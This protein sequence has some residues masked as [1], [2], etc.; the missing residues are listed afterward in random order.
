MDESKNS[1]LSSKRSLGEF[2]TSNSVSNYV[3]SKIL[4]II[5]PNLLIEPFAGEGSLIG[6]FIELGIRCVINELNEK[7]FAALQHK[8][9]RKNVSVYNKDFIACELPYL[10]KEWIE[11]DTNKIF[12]FY[13]NP[14]FGTSSTNKL[15][16]KKFEYKDKK[17]R[18][19]KINYSG[20]EQYGK[21]DLLLPAIGKMIEFIKGIGSGYLAFYSPLGLF[22]K[23]KRYNKLLQALLK[24]FTFLWG[25]IFSGDKFFN[26]NKKKPIVVSVWQY[27]KNENTSISSMK[28]YY[29]TKLIPLKQVPLLKDYWRYD[30]RKRL[31]GEIAVQGNDRFNVMAPKLF[32]LKVEKGGSE[33]VPENLLKLLD[34]G[35]IPDE[36]AIGLWSV[37]VGHRS[38][39]TYPIYM[40]NAYVHIPD[41][42]NKEVKKILTMALISV[43]ISEKLNNYTNGKIRIDEKSGECYFGN[44]RLTEG[45]RFLLKTYDS[46]RIKD[47]AVPEILNQ[48]RSKDFIIDNSRYWRKI[49][50]EEIENL[51][52]EI[53]YWDFIPLPQT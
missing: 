6:P 21:G 30:T 24:D 48:L 27:I 25:E 42:S 28:F 41:F 29:D 36:L 26:V 19:I 31:Y 52:Y 1:Q 5:K 53:A 43:L 8:F 20:L 17:S 45:A 51:L 35:Y 46:L 14:P 2:F 40:D 49:L 11:K 47:V 18:N 3:G 37:T 23:R 50:R 32:H 34:V 15:A 9:E 44:Q 12:L 39:T 16:S 22:C 10:R 38:L 4:S 7:N 33:L 13:T